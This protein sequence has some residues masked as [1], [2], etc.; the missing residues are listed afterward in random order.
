MGIRILRWAA[1]KVPH[2]VTEMWHLQSQRGALRKF[3]GLSFSPPTSLFARLPALQNSLSMASSGTS[4]GKGRVVMASPA[5]LPGSVRL[6]EEIALYAL[7]YCAHGGDTE[8]GPFHER[9]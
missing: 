2:N 6:R 4:E 7:P 1:E 9:P 3:R 5:V 8:E